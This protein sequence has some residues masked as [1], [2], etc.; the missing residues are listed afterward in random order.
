MT[1]LRPWVLL[2]AVG[3]AACSAE[4]GRSSAHPETPGLSASAPV[5]DLRLTVDGR[6]VGAG[7]ADNPA[8][9]DLAGLL[10]LRLSFRDLNGVEKIARLPRPLTTDGVPGGSDPEV[11]DIGYYAPTSDLV[12]Y[13]GDV[14]FYDGIVN[15]GRF[16]A[17]AVEWIGS[18]PDGAAV[19][20]E[21]G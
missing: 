8:A 4:P 1:A 20:I 18:R 5:G 21:R 14:G 15:V 19:T 6:D 9:R 10:P 2:V 17:E 12:L 16:D 3:L 7:L 11:A 13:Y